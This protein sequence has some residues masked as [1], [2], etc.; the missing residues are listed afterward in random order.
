MPH[1]F[2]YLS[3]C[4]K[5][6][7]EMFASLGRFYDCVKDYAETPSEENLASLQEEADKVDS[8]YESM[9]ASLASLVREIESGGETDT[10]DAEETKDGF[11]V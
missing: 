4:E 11:R 10:V 1:D 8:R 2:A 5:R 9:K 7:A 3:R 6:I